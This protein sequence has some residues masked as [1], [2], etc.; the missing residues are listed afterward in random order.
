MAVIG[1]ST[2]TYLYGEISVWT[3]RLNRPARWSNRL[4]RDADDSHVQIGQKHLTLPRRHRKHRGPPRPR[5]APKNLPGPVPR[6]K[7]SSRRACMERRRMSFDRHMAGAPSGRTPASRALRPLTASRTRA[8]R[9][10]NRALAPD[11]H[12][13]SSLPVGLTQEERGGRSDGQNHGCADHRD[14]RRAC[15]ARVGSD[16]SVIG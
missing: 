8:S 14:R 12:R 4:P 15:S 6:L 3:H 7:R 9:A 1:P 11:R 2:L 10:R 13:A 5:L 16:P